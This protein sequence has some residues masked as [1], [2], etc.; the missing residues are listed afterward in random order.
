[1]I[2]TLKSGQWKTSDRQSDHYRQSI[3]IF[4]RRNLRYPFFATFDRPAANVQKRSPGIHDHAGGHLNALLIA[5][6]HIVVAGKIHG[7]RVVKL[8][9]R[10]DHILRQVDDDGT[11][12]PGRRDCRLP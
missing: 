5:G 7:S 10:R 12:P 6:R 2:K 9:F 4:A 3:Y 1:M 11:G 8:R